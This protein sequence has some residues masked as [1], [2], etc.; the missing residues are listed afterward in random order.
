MVRDTSFLLI[1]NCL[2]DLKLI[3]LNVFRII[4]LLWTRNF[5]S[6]RIRVSF[7]YYHFYLKD[8]GD[9]FW[10][11]IL[12]KLFMINVGGGLFF[13]NNNGHCVLDAWRSI[14]LIQSFPPNISRRNS[15]TPHMY[16]I[17]LLVELLWCMI[18]REFKS[19]KNI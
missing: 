6:M 3:L 7:N 14:V 11:I 18:L 15:A 2:D 16:C 17:I 10:I 5:T 19:R 9:V 12:K 4:I 13:K 1:T 8:Y